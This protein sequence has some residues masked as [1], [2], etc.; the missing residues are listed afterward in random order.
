LLVP[1]SRTSLCWCFSTVQMQLGSML[2]AGGGEGN[3]KGP[4][5]NNHASFRNLA[6]ITLYNRTTLEPLQLTDGVW[7]IY[8]EHF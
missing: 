4:C 7:V 6:S 8:R 1:S 5:P 3:G 2:R